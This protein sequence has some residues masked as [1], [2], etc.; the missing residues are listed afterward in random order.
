KLGVLALFGPVSQPDTFDYVRYADAIVDGTFRHV[1]LAADPMPVTLR[2]V[3]GYPA[4]IAAA[5]VIAGRD[6]AWSVVP[7]QFGVALCAPAMVYRLSRA[8]GL[9][10]WLC[11]GV[12]AA[13][14]TTMQFVVDQAVLSDSLAGSTSTIVTC[15][16][17]LVALRRQPRSLAV[18]LGVGVLIAVAFLIRE[19]MIYLAAGLVPLAVC[20]VVG[21]RSRPRCWLAFA[22]IFLPL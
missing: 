13:Q 15:I 18:Y 11:L 19:V 6:W 5:K 16:L 20:A 2:R 3:I 22:L 4:I 1:D 8:F 9:G 12:V 7:L 17:G 21:E 14:A 10:I